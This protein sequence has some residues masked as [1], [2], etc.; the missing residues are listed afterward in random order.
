MVTIGMGGILSDRAPRA[1]AARA[2]GG[3]RVTV[4]TRGSRNAEVKRGQRDQSPQPIGKETPM[5]KLTPSVHRPLRTTAPA[6]LSPC[7]C[8][9]LAALAGCAASTAET[10]HTELRYMLAGVRVDPPAT[11]HNSVYVEFQDQTGQGGDFEDTIYSEIVKGVQARGY[12]HAKDHSQADY[13]MWATLRIFTEA[14]TKEG[15]AALANLGAI[16]G[17]VAGAGATHAAGGGPLATWAGAV[18][19][20]GAAGVAVAMLTKENSYQ[21][22][23]DLQLAKK[24]EGGV[25]TDTSSGGESGLAQVTLARGEA[26][27]SRMGQTK[28]QHMVETKVHFEMEQRVL[29]LASGRRLTMETARA[30]LVPKLISGLKSA[31]PRAN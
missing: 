27:A 17:G 16:A 20:A 6:R 18:A 25:Q 5:S 21:M 28:S 10:A 3:G 26:G 31:L 14:G 12:V 19:G 13:V 15:D 4:F 29:A 30:A 8:L 23:I 24:V 7:L 1:S 2:A 22:V 11:G 9:C